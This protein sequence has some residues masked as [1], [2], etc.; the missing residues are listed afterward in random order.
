MHASSAVEG[1]R[2]T[3]TAESWFLRF[4]KKLTAITGV[5]LAVDDI[6]NNKVTFHFEWQPAY[7]DC[8]DR[9]LNA[10]SIGQYR[11]LGQS[12]RDDPRGRINNGLRNMPP[13]SSRWGPP[14]NGCAFP[15]ALPAPPAARPAGNVEQAATARPSWLKLVRCSA[16]YLRPVTARATAGTTGPSA[17]GDQT[18]PPSGSVLLHRSGRERATTLGA[19]CYRDVR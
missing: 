3:A 19:T 15:M 6:W 1:L 10:A 4:Y 12:G 2:P 16:Q 17:V 8:S 14:P 9:C 18:L 5:R 11:S 7:G 13:A